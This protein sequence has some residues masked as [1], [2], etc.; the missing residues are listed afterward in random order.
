MKRFAD[1][2][3][4]SDEETKHHRVGET[5]SVLCE[6]TVLPISGKRGLRAMVTVNNV[7][8]TPVATAPDVLFLW[9]TSGSMKCN[10]QDSQLA[11]EH[12]SK[13][14]QAAMGD[15][16]I[17]LGT[18]SSLSCIP[19]VAPEM[20]DD[21]PFGYQPWML[22][23]QLTQEAAKNYALRYLKTSDAH[24]S[25]NMLGMLK[26]ALGVLKER[27]MKVHSGNPAHLQHL[28]I[29]TDGK[30]D[31]NQTLTALSEEIKNGIGD[32]SVVVHTLLL[33]ESIDLN[34]S[35]ALCVSTTGGVMAY[36]EKAA[37][38]AEAFDAILKPIFTSSRGF[39]LRVES[40]GVCE[41][42]HLGI[43]SETNNKAMVTLNFAP[44]PETGNNMGAKVS[45]LDSDSPTLVMPYYTDDPEDPAWASA[46]AKM[47][48]DLEEFIKSTNLEERIFQELLEVV[49]KD[50]F[51]AAHTHA[52]ALILEHEANLPP[53]ILRR[54]RAFS[55]DLQDQASRNSSTATTAL[56]RAISV[57]ASYSR[58]RY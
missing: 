23:N 13:L 41:V 2:N 17:A 6:T 50:G 57:T 28:V 55:L 1:S 18:W 40:N 34:L 21:L 46:A 49:S 48:I 10:M 51:E 52:N 3:G 19:G 53:P 29:L 39:T 22:M 58:V 38:I 31:P 11:M 9:D 25:T 16:H 7:N 14:P 5:V 24:G 54:V 30:P 45:L 37:D 15:I 47:P 43:L 33:G 36:A 44:K 42:K 27:R 32:F 12:I 35:K 26:K 20:L 56:S 4:S 8:Q